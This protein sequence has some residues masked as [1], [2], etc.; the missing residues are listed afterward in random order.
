VADVPIDP[1]GEGAA[2]LPVDEALSTEEAHA[3]IGELRARAAAVKVARDA[4]WAE[5][6]AARAKVGALESTAL[7]LR[8]RDLRFRWK[9]GEVILPGEAPLDVEPP[10]TTLLEVHAERW[11]RRADALEATAKELVR[12]AITLTKDADVL[13]AR[14]AERFRTGLL[15][16]PEGSILPPRIL[17]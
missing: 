2:R 8:A 14:Q 7:R 5:V 11:R 17:R 10:D 6:S 16:S 3:R 15:L 1:K 9:P 13:E 4:A 12:D